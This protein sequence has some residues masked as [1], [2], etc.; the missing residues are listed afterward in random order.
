MFSLADNYDIE[1]QNKDVNNISFTTMVITLKKK[2]KKNMFLFDH[3]FKTIQTYTLSMSYINNKNNTNI[4]NY[5]KH[6]N[7]VYN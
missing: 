2:K 3:Y 6:G 4:K 7:N 1:L 5:S